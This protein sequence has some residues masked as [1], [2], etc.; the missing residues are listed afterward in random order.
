MNGSVIGKYLFG[1]F[2]SLGIVLANNVKTPTCQEAVESIHEEYEKVSG[3]CLYDYT[4]LKALSVNKELGIVTC[5]AIVN[6]T[7][8]NMPG[9]NYKGQDVKFNAKYGVIVEFEE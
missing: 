9:E 2:I 1:A 6:R 4:K 7:C 8:P 5:Q 3:D